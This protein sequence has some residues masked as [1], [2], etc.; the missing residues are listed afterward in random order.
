MFMVDRERF[1][2]TAKDA[3][4]KSI[5]FSEVAATDQPDFQSGRTYSSFYAVPE[6]RMV[7]CWNRAT[8]NEFIFNFKLQRKPMKKES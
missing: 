5:F 7:E 2:K 3:V 4:S 6:Q 8:P 1:I